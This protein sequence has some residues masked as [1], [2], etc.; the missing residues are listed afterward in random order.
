V[1]SLL[2]NCKTLGK[3]RIAMLEKL[4]T[5]FNTYGKVYLVLMA[6]GVTCGIITFSNTYNAYHLAILSV[7]SSLLAFFGSVTLFGIWASFINRDWNIDKTNQNDYPV[8]ILLGAVVGVLASLVI[9]TY[10]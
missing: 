9:L 5:E 6:I 7:L 8:S 4:K 10:L 1:Y 3:R 2:A